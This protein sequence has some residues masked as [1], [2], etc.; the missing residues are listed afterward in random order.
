MY[1]KRRIKNTVW[2]AAALF[3]FAASESLI[4]A[5]PQPYMWSWEEKTSEKQEKFDHLLNANYLKGKRIKNSLNQTLGGV[6]ELVLDDNQNLIYYVVLSSGDKLYP[7]PWA[8]FES[9]EGKYMLN[10]GKSNF[11]NAPSVDSL[12]LLTLSSTDYRKK[13]RSFYEEQ[14]SMV[15]KED[16]AKK[17]IRWMKETFDLEEEPHLY[18]YSDVVG[19]D[20]RN[21]QDKSLAN[22][23]TLI[24][25]VRRGNVAYALVSYGG[26]WGI[27]EKTAAVPWTCLTVQ[28]KKSVAKIDAT[29]KTIEA[30]VVEKVYVKKLAQSDFARKLHENFGIE[31][32]WEIYGFVPAEETEMSAGPWRADSMYNKSF[33]PDNI[34]TI[35]GTIT[36][37][38]K[39]YPEEN[40]L[41]GTSLKLKT[42][43]GISVTVYAGPHGFATHKNVEIKSGNEITVTGSKT[44]IDG[45]SVIMASEIEID[46]KTLKLRDGDGKPQWKAEQ[47]RHK[48]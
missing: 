32:Y 21:Q 37:V 16:A 26:F 11:S 46:G 47:F 36:S 22:I 35:Q 27:G 18:T 40:A 14:I 15:R 38:G 29:Q 3:V 23:E 39:F 34:T 8:A 10:I 45:K 25:D 44:T 30:A 17:A 9:S 19:L 48:K 28:P 31:P 24:I 42:K 33:D 6:R 20:V 4:A 12:A 7:V 43:E 41:P 5:M 13:V 2:I 1:E